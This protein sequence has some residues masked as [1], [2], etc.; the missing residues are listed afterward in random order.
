MSNIGFK[1]ILVLIL[2]F[3]YKFSYSQ[4]STK[5]WLEIKETQD[6]KFGSIIDNYNKLNDK[7]KEKWVKNW[8]KFKKKN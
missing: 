4:D 5:P 3:N 8:I 1:L 7:A 2:I 6:Q